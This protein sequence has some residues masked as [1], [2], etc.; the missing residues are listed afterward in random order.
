M[1]NYPTAMDTFVII[2]F[3]F[4]FTAM[5]EFAVITFISLYINRYKAK[6]EKEREALEKLVKIVNEKLKSSDNINGILC[7][8][9]INKLQ[10]KDQKSVERDKQ[11]VMIENNRNLE[12][13]E[14][15]QVG[16]E[17]TS[18][19]FTPKGCKAQL[20]LYLGNIYK[21]L[22]EEYKLCCENSCEG[23]FQKFMCCCKMIRQY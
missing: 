1:V 11:V 4:V 20:K 14:I 8:E 10:N 15:I 22:P 5:L 13:I 6:E 3:G 2:C 19:S 18:K 23:L 12:S 21:R 9:L 7:N 16:Q 17:R